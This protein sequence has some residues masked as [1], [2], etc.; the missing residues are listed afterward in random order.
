[1]IGALGAVHDEV[2]MCT[3]RRRVV[4]A[5]FAFAAAASA[6]LA[7]AAGPVVAAPSMPATSATP[8]RRAAAERVAILLTDWAEPEGF[9]PLY[10]REVVKR[11]FGGSAARPDEPCTESYVG[12]APFRV[13]LGLQPYALGFKVAGLEAV[14]DSIGLYR[15]SADGQTYVSIYDPAVTLAAKDVPTTPGM[16]TAAKDMKKPLQRSFWA[17]DPRDGT[18]YLEGVVMIGA[19]ARGPGPNPLAMPNGI[20]DA[21]EYSWA[22]AITDFSILH[23]DLA[24]RLSPATVVVESTTASVLQQLFGDQVDVRFGAYAPTTGLTRFE[25]DVALDFAREGFRR[26][27]L[28]RETTDNNNY[29]NNFMTK[30]YVQRALCLAGHEDTFQYQQSRQVGRT[31]EYNLALLHVAKKNLDNLKPGS[32]VAI[33]YTT[34]GLPFPDRPAQGPFAAP[35]PWSSEVYHENA[36]NNYVAFKRYLEAYYGERYR[37]HFNPVGRTGERRLD[38]YFSYGIS[39]P[40]DFTSPDPANRFR[41]LR[42]NIDLAKQEGRRNII[43]VLSHWYYNGRDPLLAIRAVQQ[44]PLNTR[45]DFR[46]GKF[47]VDWCEKPGSPAPVPCDASDPSV[48]Y[49]QYSETFDSWAKEFGIGY[50]QNVRSAVERF[51]VFPV[52]TGLE[53]VAR[54]AVDREGGGVAAVKQGPLTGARV[55]VA[56]DAHP[57]EPESFDA[58]TYRAFADPAD[59]LVSAWDSFEAYVGT[60]HVPLPNLAAHSEVVSPAVLFGPYRTIVNRPATFTLPVSRKARLSADEATRLKAFIY[61]EVSRDWDPVFVPAGSA[62]LRYDPKTR[63]ASFDAQVFGVFALAVTP[64]GWTPVKAI[65]HRYNQP[66]APLASRG[67]ASLFPPRGD[68]PLSPAK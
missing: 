45:A 57:G 16:I 46:N 23:E 26:M 56:R 33:L 36:Y 8:A 32:E 66:P 28:V 65:R 9:D 63:T 37:L 30:G 40:T 17:L 29:A 68:R 43:A 4:G 50:A 64:P 55:V 25:E 7:V 15:R 60:Q 2:A 10:R 58:R 12:A 41:T 6:S 19:P 61:N 18:N 67:D 13:Q 3:F 44:I 20:R 14:Y 52:S 42:E 35:H 11:S 59:N 21:D 51:G 1:M 62:P 38:N 5:L 47:W 53:I 31:P 49:I 34:Y 39:P 54:G 24:P 27:V 22:G 48:S